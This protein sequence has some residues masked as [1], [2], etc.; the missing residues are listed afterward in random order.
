M[1]FA[2]REHLALRDMTPEEQQPWSNWPD[3][4]RHRLAWCSGRR[5]TG[6]GIA[7]RSSV[8]GAAAIAPEGNPVSL[9]SLVPDDLPDEPLSPRTQQFAVVVDN[10]ILGM[11]TAAS[12][13]YTS[14]STGSFY[15]TASGA[16]TITFVGT[17][18]GSGIALIDDVG[19][20]ATPAVKLSAS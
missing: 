18:F 7:I 15:V 17:N 12:T 6:T 5:T 11:G 10:T 16:Y 13:Q 3:R 4:E 1:R 20:N 14:Y 19:L 2:M 9:P 8:A